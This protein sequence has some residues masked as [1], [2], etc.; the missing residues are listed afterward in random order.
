V[1]LYQINQLLFNLV[2]DLEKSESFC[3]FDPWEKSFFFALL[4]EFP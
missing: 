3:H 1:S 2:N 4:T